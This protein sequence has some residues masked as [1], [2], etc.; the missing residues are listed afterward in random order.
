[1]LFHFPS[2]GIYKRITLL[3]YFEITDKEETTQNS[4]E[5]SHEQGDYK[6]SNNYRNY[7]CFFLSS[8]WSDFFKSPSQWS[9]PSNKL[10]IV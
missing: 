2:C 5:T 1:M 10:M 6:Y 9:L 3:W 8:L 4:E 7:P